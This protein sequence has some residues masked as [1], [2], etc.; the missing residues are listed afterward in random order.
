MKRIIL[1]IALLGIIASN[2]QAQ[3]VGATDNT[4]QGGTIRLDNTPL[5][6]PTGGSLRF[7]IGFPTFVS[8]GYNHFLTSSLMVGGGV[9]LG[10]TDRCENLK[11]YKDKDHLEFSYERNY[12]WSVWSSLPVYAEAEFRTPQYKWSLFANIRLGVNIS[13]EED[14]S[15]DYD[16]EITTYRMASPLYLAATVGASYKNLNLGIGY[17]YSK[18]FPMCFNLSYNLPITTLT[19]TISKRFF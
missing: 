7:A 10:Q 1:I 19:T 9:G 16:Y 12:Y 5:Y 8:V 13:L 11:Y 4:S 14:F 18:D 3:M 2:A 17:Y 6:R 15:Y